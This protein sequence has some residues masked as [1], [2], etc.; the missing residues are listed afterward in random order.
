MMTRVRAR[1]GSTRAADCARDARN[2]PLPGGEKKAAVR[3]RESSPKAD[4]VAGVG[5]ARRSAATARAPPRP[6]APPPAAARRPRRTRAGARAAPAT[7]RGG[8]GRRVCAGSGDV[9][10][11]LPPPRA[12]RRPRARRPARLGPRATAS[13]ASARPTRSSAG[14]T[15]RASSATRATGQVHRPV[16]RAVPGGRLSRAGRAATAPSTTPRSRRGSRPPRCSR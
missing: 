16:R 7:A 9:G 1:S 4:W 15:G 11:A 3:K 12:R 8:G 5:R 13:R 14:T 2:D 10:P 6:R